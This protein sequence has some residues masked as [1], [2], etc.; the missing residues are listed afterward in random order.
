MNHD[1]IVEIISRLLF[2]HVLGGKDIGS[3]SVIQIERKIIGSFI[4]LIV[5]LLLP[6][7]VYKCTALKS[8]RATE[9]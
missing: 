2:I 4:T 7:N 3:T 5:K 9:R 6:E 1:S 8:I